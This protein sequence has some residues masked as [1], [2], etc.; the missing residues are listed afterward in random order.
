VVLIVA[1]VIVK[2]K[3]CFSKVFLPGLSFSTVI[4]TPSVRQRNRTP[5]PLKKAP[6][7]AGLGVTARVVVGY[8]ASR[9]T[10][11]AGK[12]THVSVMPRSCPDRGGCLKLEGAGYDGKELR[13][14]G[15]K[16]GSGLLYIY[17]FMLVVLSKSGGGAAVICVRG[18]VGGTM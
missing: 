2:M 1:L 13:G 18:A 7:P 10:R 5:W 17:L 3:K 15:E 4:P 14:I 9:P 8:A 6:E 16:M 12:G 11:P